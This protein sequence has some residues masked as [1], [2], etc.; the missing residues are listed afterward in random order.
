MCKQEREY[1]SLVQVTPATWNQYHNFSEVCGDCQNSRRFKLWEKARK[2]AARKAA[3]APT[4]HAVGT[5]SSTGKNGSQPLAVEIA[6]RRTGALLHTVKNATLAGAKLSG[7]AL[8][9]AD[10]Q[11]A[12]LRGANLH[13]AD[14]HLADLTGADLRGAD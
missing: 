12:G 6:H 10:L 4:G 1:V 2:P 9:G 3:I 11:H 14:L 7:A 5:D 8:S 13:R